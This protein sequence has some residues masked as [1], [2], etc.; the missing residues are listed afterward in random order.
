MRR[1]LLRGGQS[2]NLRNAAA[3]LHHKL[4]S[5]REEYDK[6]EDILISHLE[7]D[8]SSDLENYLY[9]LEE[10][11]YEIEEF[12]DNIDRLD[13]AR[14]NLEEH[15]NPDMLATTVNLNNMNATKSNN[16]HFAHFDIAG[17]SY[18]EGCLVMHRLKIGTKVDLIREPDNRHDPY[19]V[20][21]RFD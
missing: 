5:A 10:Y 16:L 14:A 12:A 19:A 15:R 8:D 6:M 2:F 21:V 13:E 1:N 18:W 17:F 20:A 9:D 7:D 3:K 11:I 4:E